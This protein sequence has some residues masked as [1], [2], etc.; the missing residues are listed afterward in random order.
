M[1][2]EILSHELFKRLLKD[3]G[4]RAACAELSKHVAEA[5]VIAARAM[6]LG[7]WDE[8]M[9]EDV[10]PIAHDLVTDSLM[11]VAEAVLEHLSR[12]PMGEA[13][14]AHPG[15]GLGSEE[16]EELRMKSVAVQP[17]Q[18]AKQTAKP[19]ASARMASGKSASVD[20]GGFAESDACGPGCE[21]EACSA[22]LDEVYDGNP[23][24]GQ[25]YDSRRGGPS[26]KDAEEREER[27]ARQA[28]LKRRFEYGELPESD[29]EEEGDRSDYDAPHV[30]EM[31]LG[32][33]GTPLNLGSDSEDDDEDLFVAVPPT[34]LRST[35]RDAADEPKAKKKPTKKS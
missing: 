9:A 21:C 20:W 15:R 29:G 10:R 26:M 33:A 30:D 5:S 27:A 1:S 3:T 34:Y 11:R 32:V 13:A 17:K 35:A 8:D 7:E 25:A 18:Q 23:A 6:G 12:G 24:M 16:P 31:K 4:V 19:A 28:K 14:A 2:D 22:G